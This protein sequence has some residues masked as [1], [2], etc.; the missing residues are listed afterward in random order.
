[1][2]RYGYLVVEGPHDVE[3]AYR[4]LSPFGL[5]RVHRESELD[6]F[7][8]PLIPRTFPYDGELQKRVPVPLFLRSDTHAIAIHSA[9]GDSRLVE[10]IQEN[11]LMIDYA[12]LT[13]V[14]II[15]DTDREVSA[16]KRYEAVKTKM[17]NLG[18][19][20]PEDP[21]MI[22][23]S[24]P[25]YGAFVLPDN[26][27]QG[28]LEDLLIECAQS[29]FPDLL[30]SARQHVTNARDDASFQDPKREDLRKPAEF[31]KAVV[32]AIATTLRPGRAVQTSIQD[33]IWLRGDNLELPK[34]KAVQDFLARLFEL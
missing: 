1:M 2:P 29:A 11:S 16:L 8:E 33:N 31:G 4:L 27:S 28:N 24:S 25:K 5:D 14:G 6:S 13:G 7:F 23:D 17:T 9:V 10:T 12:E 18:F 30:S 26:E 21:G 15:L 22:A 3:F 20:L 32:G 19:H 34:V